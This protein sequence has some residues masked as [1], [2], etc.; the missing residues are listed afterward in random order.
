MA[1]EEYCA[2]CTELSENGDYSG[3]YYCFNFGEDRYACDP[4]CHRFS[5][6]YSRS[7]SARKNMYNN[8]LSHQS[9]G[10]CYLTTAMCYILGYPD[11]NYYLET[12]RMFRDNILKKDIKYIPLLLMYDVIGPQISAN[13]LKDQDKEIIAKTL[14]TQYITKSVT[15]IENNK[16]Q[17]AVNIYIAMTNSL[18]NKYNINTHILEINPQSINFDKVDINSLGHGRKKVKRLELTQTNI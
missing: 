17:E 6:A 4:K 8:S 16:I 12:L 2:A 18:A 10:G 3:K 5:E 14:F 1:L 15:A 11:N 7:D 9:G 13:L